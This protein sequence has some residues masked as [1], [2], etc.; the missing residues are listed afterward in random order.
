MLDELG[1]LRDG[2]G[3]LLRV[4]QGYVMETRCGAFEETGAGQPVPGLRCGAEASGWPW[5]DTEAAFRKSG[6]WVPDL[7]SHP[8]SVPRIG[9]GDK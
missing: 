5:R 2:W 9:R 8:G 3:S 4:G 6:L 1:T 7:A